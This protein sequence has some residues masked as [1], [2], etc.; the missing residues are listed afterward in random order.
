MKARVCGDGGHHRVYCHKVH[1]YKAAIFSNSTDLCSLKI[2]Y[3]S[4]K[5]QGS[6]PVGG[7]K[8]TIKGTQKDALLNEMSLG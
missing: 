7:W 6:S 3:D 1:P 5:S 2:S 8:H 4:R